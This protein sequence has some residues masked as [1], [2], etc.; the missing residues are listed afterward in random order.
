MKA[1]IFLVTISVLLGCQSQTVQKPGSQPTTSKQASHEHGDHPQT[2]N[3]GHQM[4]KM[5]SMTITPQEVVVG[6]PIDL[7]IMVKDVKGNVVKD[8]EATHEKLVHLIFID[9][10]MATFSHLHPEIAPDGRMTFSH[11]FATG[12]DFYVYADVKPRGKE[13]ETVRSM[14]SVKG[15]PPSSVSLASTVPG[16]VKGEG[17]VAKVGVTPVQVGESIVSFD[18]KANDDK[19]LNDL[20]PYLGAMGHL[21]VVNTE[22]GDYAHAHP[23]EKSSA[24][25]NVRFMVH[26]AKPGLYKGWGQFKRESKVFDVPFVVQV[27]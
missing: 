25:G 4:G 26:F 17:W 20:Q 21:V 10:R 14:L 9:K 12:G 15:E 1:T 16:S 27:K 8:F 23:D 22:D 24:P 19:P 13:V 18:F 3:E 11:T 5:L 6:K 7:T 2:E